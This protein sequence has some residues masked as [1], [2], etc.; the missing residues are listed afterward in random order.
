MIKT[1][2]IAFDKSCN[3]IRGLGG[4]QDLFGLRSDG[5]CHNDFTLMT[6]TGQ[7][8][9]N[10][11]EIYTGYILSNKFLAEVYQNEEGTFM[12]KFHVNP[13]INKP[14]SLIKYLKNRKQAGTEIRDN[15]VIGNIYENPELLK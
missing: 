6:F 9:E 2:F 14:I 7:N 11:N 1:K 8:D 3:K 15:I 5:S 10:K 4:V 13:Q 12:V